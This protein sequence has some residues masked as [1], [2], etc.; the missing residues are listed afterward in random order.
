MKH[1][2]KLTNDPLPAIAAMLQSTRE[3]LEQIRNNIGN[4]T[5]P[6]CGER[7]YCDFVFRGQKYRLDATDIIAK[8]GHIEELNAEAD[9]RVASTLLVQELSK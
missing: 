5:W 3:S 6:I 9:K 2:G 4:I 7:V 1:E 8:T